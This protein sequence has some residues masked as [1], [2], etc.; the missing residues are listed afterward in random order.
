MRNQFTFLNKL[1]N[2]W[3]SVQPETW[4]WRAVYVDGRELSQ[5]NDANGR[6]HQFAEIDQSQLSLFI[7]ESPHFGH[8]FELIFQPDMK[9]IHFYRNLDTFIQT[10]FD[11]Q[12][13]PEGFRHK[14]RFVVFGYETPSGKRLQAVDKQGNL[15]LTDKL[16]DITIAKGRKRL[17][18]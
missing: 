11:A 18:A 16:E 5:F 9:L 6:F 12:G 17:V 15:Y 10:G 3:E 7:I 14:E 13:N 1:T 8:H 4:R 2:E